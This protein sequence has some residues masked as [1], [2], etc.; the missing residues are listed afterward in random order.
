MRAMRIL[1]I[2][3]GGMKGVYAASYLEKLEELLDSRL[4]ETFD[5]V[6]GTSTGGIIALG[7][8]AGKPL[9]DILSF[10]RHYGPQI[11]PR[12]MGSGKL[13]WR[14]FRLGSAHNQKALRQSLQ[15]TF[16]HEDGSPI[17]MEDS[18]V[19]LCVPAVYAT[20]CGPRVFK[21]VLPS[22]AT[23]Q[24]Y[25]RD[26]KLPMWQVALAT[27][28]A[29]MYYPLATIDEGGSKQQYVDGGLWA[30]NPSL[31]GISEAL[32]NYSGDGKEFSGI[33]LLSVAL[34]KSGGYGY[35]MKNPRGPGLFSRLLS[36]SL[37]SGKD[38][39]HFMASY[40]L[41]RPEDEYFRTTPQV[42]SK[43]QDKYI[44]LDGA[45]P[46]AIEDLV[47]QGHRDALTDWAKPTLKAIFK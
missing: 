8:G 25:V 24:K 4:C 45:S 39:V 42:L 47:S 35:H 1:S 21:S 31:V 29:P 15:E 28:A 12:S 40:M 16:Q 11:F 2:D 22:D 33:K 10:Y 23:S 38:S 18:C 6:V 27:S 5:L 20:S 17:L 46:R 14:S 43:D 3:G 13:L 36:Y 9:S 26:P 32:Q 41:C 44:K 37:E 30:N 34:P 19:K 7:I